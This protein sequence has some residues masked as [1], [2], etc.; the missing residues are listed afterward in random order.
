MKRTLHL[1]AGSLAGVMIATFWLSTVLAGQ[2][3][4]HVR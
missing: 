4:P 1:V 2:G 3:V